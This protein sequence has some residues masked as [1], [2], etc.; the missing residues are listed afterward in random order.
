[1]FFIVLEKFCAEKH[2]YLISFIYFLNIILFKRKCFL[3]NF[4]AISVLFLRL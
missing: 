3:E 4:K 1:M 2:I